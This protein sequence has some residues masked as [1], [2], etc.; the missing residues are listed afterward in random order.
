MVPFIF[1]GVARET[2]MR[3][4]LLPERLGHGQDNNER[5]KH[6]SSDAPRL[7]FG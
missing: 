2:P 6:R 4:D 3:D 1:F 7:F 5:T